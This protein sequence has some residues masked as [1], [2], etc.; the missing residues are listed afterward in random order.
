MALAISIHKGGS[1]ILDID[2]HSVLK[3]IM[4]YDIPTREWI[5]TL[6]AKRQKIGSISGLALSPDGSQMAILTDG[7]VETY[8]LPE[9]ASGPQSA[10]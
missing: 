10:Q 1:E 7:V 5:Y 6:A 3:R 8:R 2:Y 4:V 9:R